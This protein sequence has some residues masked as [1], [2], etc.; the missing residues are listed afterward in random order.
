MVF[1]RQRR[2]NFP[3]PPLEKPPFAVVAGQLEVPVRNF[4]LP[5]PRL[6]ASKQIS[7]R[8]VHQVIGFQ[9]TG[10]GERADDRQR[11]SGPSTLATATARFRDT[12]GE[13]CTRSSRS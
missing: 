8:G 4:W 6:Y 10:R 2:T 5:L 1:S 12:I 3:Q 11:R 13:G 9:L 7:S